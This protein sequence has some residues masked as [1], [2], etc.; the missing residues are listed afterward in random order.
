MRRG[1][2]FPVWVA[3]L[4]VSASAAAP[5]AA[6]VPVRTRVD[7]AFEAA[8]RG[9][10]GP[11]SDLARLGGTA[12][13][14]IAPYAKDG[15]EEVR[16][17][18]VVLLGL[19]GDP[20]ALAP[21]AGALQDG[22]AEVRERAVTALYDR[23]PPQKVAA[24]PR[25]ASGLRA[26]AVRDRSAAALLLLSYLPGKETILTLEQACVEEPAVKLRPWTRPVP[27]SL[28]A[29]VA[30]SRIGEAAGRARLLRALDEGRLETME[31]VLL[32]LREVDTP[33]VLA[34]LGKK[35]LSDERE[36]G[37]GAPSGATPPR[38]VCDLAV[39]Q[40]VRHL[41]LKVGFSPS[42]SRRYTASEIGQ[43]LGAMKLR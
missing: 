31:F 38:R 17:Q 10:F 30:L 40:L 1:A 41:R 4:A 33:E 13:P 37:G 28:P 27:P 8:R 22:S 5:P 26:V 42:D 9:D 6:P 18:A 19:S 2:G 32:A 11:S 34:A 35:A 14:F 23:F 21:L 36:I 24:E 25:A 16:R 20:Q 29:A 3:L 7:Q 43:V 39:T 12:V 15:S